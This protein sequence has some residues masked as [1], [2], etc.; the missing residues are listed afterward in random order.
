MEKYISD[1]LR[2]VMEEIYPSYRFQLNGT[3]LRISDHVL[4]IHPIIESMIQRDSEWICAARFEITIDKSW[5]A[6]YTSTGI[7]VGAT[8]DEAQEVSVNEWL[9][10]GFSLALVSSLLKD[11][12]YFS[13]EEYHVYAG[14]TLIRGDAP[15]EVLDGSKTMHHRIL[16]TLKNI[17][18]TSN[19]VPTTIS[20]MM[21]V[22]HDGLVDGECRLNG[23]VSEPMFTALNGLTWPKGEYIFK[24]VYLLSPG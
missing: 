8:K 20:L 9:Q 12:T 18:T 1:M 6:K 13:F 19:T 5:N 14:N 10:A 24:Q 22:D 15:G 4:E 17:I 11:A 2:L 21:V 3:E 23:A 7:G 16:T